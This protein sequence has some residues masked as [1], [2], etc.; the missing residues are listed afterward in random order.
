MHS[1]LGWGSF[2]IRTATYRLQWPKKYRNLQ[3]QRPSFHPNSIPYNTNG[4]MQRV[5]ASETAR[6]SISLKVKLRFLFHSRAML[7]ITAML[8]GKPTKQHKPRTTA[9]AIF[10]EP[11]AVL[12]DDE[13]KPD[14]SI[15]KLCFLE[16]ASDSS[17]IRN[18]NEQWLFEEQGL[19]WHLP[20]LNLKPQLYSHFPK[21]RVH[22]HKKIK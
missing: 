16:N 20:H 8:L 4:A 7:M 22:N 11:T 14:P 12:L 3:D 5:K 9:G 15:I 2:C 19:H 1:I 21:T 18:K 17:F 13:L 6:F 10:S